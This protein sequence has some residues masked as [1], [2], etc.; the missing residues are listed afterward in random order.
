MNQKRIIDNALSEKLDSICSKLHNAIRSFD[1][2][3]WLEN[4]EEHE[5]SSAIKILENLKYFTVAEI[6][7][8]Y[9]E[10]F[11]KSF[12]SFVIK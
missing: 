6:I 11:L 8:E 3:N 9:D 5:Q 2:L 12:V 7:Y 10:S 4:F 1:I